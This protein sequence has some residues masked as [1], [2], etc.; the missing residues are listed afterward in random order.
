VSK[1]NYLWRLFATA[2]SF[3]SF[4]V[5]GMI[6]AITILPAVWIMRRDPVERRILGKR[7][8]QLS[9]RL[10]IEFMRVMGVLRYRMVN[11]DKLK[12][13]HGALIVANHP[14][15]IDVIFLVAFVNQAD[16]VVKRSLKTNP[17]TRGP[18]S[19]AGYLINAGGES[20][21]E[22]CRDSLTSGNN[23][24]IF[25][26]GTRT[27][28]GRELMLQRGAANIALRAQVNMTPVLIRCEPTTLTK[29]EKWY[30]I[31]P[32][33][34]TM[35]LTVLDDID[36]AEVV[37]EAPNKTMASR[38]LTDYLTRFFTQE[39]LLHDRTGARSEAADH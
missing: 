5:G 23:L 8:V 33:R 19:A 28:P 17:A 11:F 22:A 3:L 35:E 39:K 29:A 16:C 27:V 37:R 21:L 4:G 38:L 1:L 20:L 9:F 13:R 15:L 12:G 24:I 18:I 34:F 7:Y 32:R 30:Q 14:S 31:P 36:V 10:F 25:P 6:I 2:L 26:E